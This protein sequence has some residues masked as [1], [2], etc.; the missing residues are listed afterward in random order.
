MNQAYLYIGTAVRIAFS[1]GLHLDKCA[2]KDNVVA[3]AYAR[4]L[5]WSLFL[6]DHDIS[7][8]LGKPCMTDSSH[9]TWNPPLPSEQAG[10]PDPEP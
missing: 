10:S 7:L 9:F 3:L 5:W 8:Q 2:A 4:R 1:L 6:L